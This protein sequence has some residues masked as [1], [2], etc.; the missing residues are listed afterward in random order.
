[1][2]LGPHGPWEDDS[3]GLG[4]GVWGLGSHPLAIGIIADQTE[5]DGLRLEECSCIHSLNRDFSCTGSMIVLFE[6]L[7]TQNEQIRLGPYFLGTQNP[8][9]RL[10]AFETVT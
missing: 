4:L 7:G 2:H 6:E 1:M 8:H 9:L 3:G 5:M 10:N